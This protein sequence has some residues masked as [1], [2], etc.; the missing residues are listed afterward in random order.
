MWTRKPFK[1][2]LRILLNVVVSIFSIRHY[3]WKYFVYLWY[4]WYAD[5]TIYLTS[6]TEMHKYKIEK[7]ILTKNKIPY[8]ITVIFYMF[9][10]S[11]FKCAF[12]KFDVCSKLLFSWS[13]TMKFSIP[14][15]HL[16]KHKIMNLQKISMAVTQF[17]NAVFKWM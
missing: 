1:R 3:F 7:C 10:S 16:I 4:S 13:W 14:H 8:S 11:K 12:S 6:T 15:N 2:M 5:I 17:S 9:A